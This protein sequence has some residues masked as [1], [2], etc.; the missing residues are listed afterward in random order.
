VL[1]DGPVKPG[2]CSR[3]IENCVTFEATGSF[4]VSVHLV[5]VPVG[6]APTLTIPVA[7]PAGTPLGTRGLACPAAD[8]TG[9]SVCSGLV[10]GVGLVPELGSLV[11]LSGAAPAPT[12]TATA[13]A[14][15]PPNNVARIAA[16]LAPD[17]Q[18]GV[19]CATALGEQ[20]QITP[21][22]AT[23]PS[24]NA[25]VTGSMSVRLTL[26]G[27]VAP[28]GA[29][30]NAFF[31]TTAGIESVACVPAVAGTATTCVGS[32]G[33]NAIQGS[34]VRI[35]VG[36]A[37]VATGRIVGGGAVGIAPLLPPA[38]PVLLP[39]PPSPLVALP[40]LGGLPLA[41][42][43]IIPEA[44]PLALLATGLAGLGAL[45]RFRRPRP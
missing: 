33:G 28:P 45:S 27:G 15:P 16:S 44:D 9:R 30:A 6:V 17:G 40:P 23:G 22:G 3:P 24:G 11:V 1:A 5:R 8:A 34:T 12:P 20:C 25:T 21:N 13:T 32:L 29:V 31:V 2:P 4:T 26:P 18:P 35:F 7:G 38:P 10:T 42:V 37:Q 43:P 19:P 36:G 14:L 41:D 39:P